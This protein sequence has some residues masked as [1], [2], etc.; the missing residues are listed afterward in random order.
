MTTPKSEL[1]PDVRGLLD[2][3]IASPKGIR[4]KL[5][6]EGQA[7]NLRQRLYTVRSRVCQ[8]NRKRYE[9]G[10]AMHDRSDWDHCVFMLANTK[11]AVVFDDGGPGVIIA[12]DPDYAA[13]FYTTEELT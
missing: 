9:L 7:I 5:H 3:A 11:G 12:H 1:T 4:V 2:K 8:A 10:H 13:S 6:T